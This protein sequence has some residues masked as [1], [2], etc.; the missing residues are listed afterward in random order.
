MERS[1][2][3]ELAQELSQKWPDSWD[4]P[5][6]K[7]PLNG[8]TVFEI[9]TSGNPYGELVGAQNYVEYYKKWEVMLKH[10]LRNPS[11]VESKSI[12]ERVEERGRYKEMEITLNNLLNV[13]DSTVQKTLELTDEDNVEEFVKFNNKVCDYL[14]YLNELVDEIQQY[15]KQNQ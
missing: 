5:G 7:F 12:R 15:L 14:P 3:I 9:L 1:K 6:L 2:N 13:T 4:S 11:N 10:L 8:M